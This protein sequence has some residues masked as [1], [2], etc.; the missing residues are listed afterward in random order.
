MKQVFDIS[1]KNNLGLSLIWTNAGKY[2][3][4]LNDVSKLVSEGPAKLC[5]FEDKKGSFHVGA[6]ADMIV[7]DQDG[8]FIVTKDLILY[9]NKVSVLKYL[10]YT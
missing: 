7:F 9:K 6:D 10:Q 2:G 3:L 8:E 4:G 1:N 5:G